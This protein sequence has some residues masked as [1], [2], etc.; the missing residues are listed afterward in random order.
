MPFW[1]FTVWKTS[2][3]AVYPTEMIEKFRLIVSRRRAMILNV[4]GGTMTTDTAIMEVEARTYSTL[5][6]AVRLR[7]SVKSS[8]T[9]PDMPDVHSK[10]E[11]TVLQLGAL[12]SLIERGDFNNVTDE[13]L[14]PLQ[15][16]LVRLHE[17]LGPSLA[18]IRKTL[19]T[20]SREYG[21][22]LTEEYE[23]FIAT[24]T[25]DQGRLASI[26][27]ELAMHLSQDFRSSLKQ[28][29]LSLE[30]ASEPIDWRKALD[31]MSDRL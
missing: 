9:E 6:S 13:Q 25:R 2:R 3:R 7:A 27:G 10:L 31:S 28:A 15:D 18:E 24:L 29:V 11:N 4:R 22:H 12:L 23:P 19:D 5:S 17:M 14:R 30:P 26:I 16:G 1:S 20:V 8:N 21:S